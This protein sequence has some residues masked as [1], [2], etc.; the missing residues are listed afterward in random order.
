M[1]SE[2]LL[3]IIERAAKRGE[4]RAAAWLLEHRESATKTRA[5]QE[6]DFVSAYPLVVNAAY[7]KPV[8]TPDYIKAIVAQHYGVELPLLSAED[9]TPHIR[10]ARV[11]LA[12]SVAMH[13]CREVL[14]PSYPEIGRIFR[15]DHGSVM[16]ACKKISED[17]D[18][19]TVQNVAFLREKLASSVTN[20]PVSE[21]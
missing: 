18:P 16:A 21:T 8:V 5:H 7:G 13:L 4:W 20:N 17:D 10:T 19:A 2:E 1:T 6:T 14:K 15:R 12:R 3:K 11:A 9:G